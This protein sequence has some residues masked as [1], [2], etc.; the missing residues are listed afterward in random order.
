MDRQLAQIR[1][2]EQAEEERDLA[3]EKR[4]I[5]EKRRMMGK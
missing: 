4:M 3:E 2:M 1:A 5:E